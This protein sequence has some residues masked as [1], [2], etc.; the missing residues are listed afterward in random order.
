MS[1]SLHN[2]VFRR[3][4]CA[5]L[6]L[7]LPASAFAAIT[8]GAGGPTVTAGTTPVVNIVA[9]NRAGVS[10]NHFEA[11]GVD[12]NGVVLN[13]SVNSVKS[14]LAGQIDGNASLKG[15]AAKVIIAEVTG[16]TATALNG[17]TEIA[18]NKAALIIANP[19]GISADGAS[20]INASRVTL[21]T[22]TPQPD[23]YG[24]VRAIDVAQGVIRVTGKGLDAT[25]VDRAEL[26]ARSIEVN[27]KVQAKQ[28]D[29]LTGANHA[30]YVYGG[31]WARE[32]SGK[33][34][35]VAL[36]VSELGGMYADSIRMVGT[37]KGVGVNVAGTVQAQN[38]NLDISANAPVNIAKSGVLKSKYDMTLNFGQEAEGLNVA[39]QVQSESG[40]IDAFGGGGV[41][42]AESGSIKAG[43][44]I[45]VRNRTDGVSVAGKL[46]A[47]TVNIRSEGAVD[48]AKTGSVKSKYDLELSSGAYYNPERALVNVEGTAESSNGSVSVNSTGSIKVAASGVAKAARDLNVSASSV[49]N[50]GALTAGKNLNVTATDVDNSGAMTANSNLNITAVNV[51]NSGEMNATVGSIYARGP[52]IW[53]RASS[54]FVSSGKISAG[55]GAYAYGFDDKEIGGTVKTGAGDFVQDDYGNKLKSG[56]SDHTGAERKKN[57]GG[58]YSPWSWG[59]MRLSLARW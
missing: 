51:T 12:A 3:E 40:S 47:D 54:K 2:I 41:K 11:F 17:A 13:N 1:K 15:G 26:F 49:S 18:G 32:G 38:G 59:A 53:S 50:A 46:E 24:R 5:A 29:V 8:P 44:D 22:G 48:V 33:A 25:G 6:A 14:Q 42:I 34:P 28:L 52:G 45:Y 56:M 21:T 19:N 58:W 20:F 23:R 39:G 36:D 27:A 9:P 30:D 4:L 10:H 16:K 35:T 57:M 31:V 55:R 7:A 37:E 43:R